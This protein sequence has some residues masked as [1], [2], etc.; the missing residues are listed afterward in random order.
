MIDKKNPNIVKVHIASVEDPTI[1]IMQDVGSLTPGLI[2][3]DSVASILCDIYPDIAKR[4]AGMYPSLWLSDHIIRVHVK[5]GWDGTLGKSHRDKHRDK[6]E[7]DHWLAGCLCVLQLDVEYG[8]GTR[9]VLWVEENPNSIL[10]SPPLGIYKGEEANRPTLSYIMYAVESEIEMLSNNYVE[11]ESSVSFPVHAVEHHVRSPSCNKP[12]SDLESSNQQFEDIM[13]IDDNE[14][15]HELKFD[16]AVQDEFLQKYRQVF[17][18]ISKNDD[19]KTLTENQRFSIRVTSPKE[20]SLTS[21]SE[22]EQELVLPSL[23]CIAIEL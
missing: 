9:S 15:S 14:K 20:K 7:C 2:N 12:V 5:Q 21:I 3:I 19:T 23:V 16:D 11:L 18:G 1:D 6:D 4:A 13:K 8:D 22:V 10:T 17:D